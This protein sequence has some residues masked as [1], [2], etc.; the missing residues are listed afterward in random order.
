LEDNEMAELEGSFP[1]IAEGNWWK[2]RELFRKKVPSVVTPTYLATALTMKEN[3]ARANIM[4]PFKKIGIFDDEG[5]PTDLA[6]TWRDD[7]KY[8]EVCSTI[9]EAT[10][11]QE[12]RDLYHDKGQDL[13]GLSS[14]FMHKCR[15]GEHAAK[16]YA[17]FYGLLLQADPNG[18][19][20]EAGPVIATAIKTAKRKWQSAQRE[21]SP[22]KSSKKGYPDSIR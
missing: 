7:A 16:R 5:R 10:Y 22:W 12:V 14:W 15:C 4:S 21:R 6:Y 19:L 18:Q 3:A 9:L 11:P 8:A 2:L 17:S 20:E 13:S 1:K